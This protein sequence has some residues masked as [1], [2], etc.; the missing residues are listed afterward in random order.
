MSQRDDE[1][2]GQLDPPAKAETVQGLKK[3]TKVTESIPN[4]GLKQTQNRSRQS[5]TNTK[6]GCITTN[7]AGLKTT[8]DYP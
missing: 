6:S 5:V 1:I 4:K 7:H 3:V 2:A 8:P